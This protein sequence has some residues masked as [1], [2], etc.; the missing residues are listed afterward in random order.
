VSGESVSQPVIIP[1]TKILA[2]V[3]SSLRRLDRLE[4]AWPPAV[5]SSACIADFSFSVLSFSNFKFQALFEN[6]ISI[7]DSF[8][9]STLA[10][11][12]KRPRT[13]QRTAQQTCAKRKAPS[14]KVEIKGTPSVFNTQHNVPSVLV[15]FF[16]VVLASVLK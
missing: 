2:R 16:Q 12:S 7:L 14:K 15:Q 3:T 9:I 6:S 13:A 1:Q 4:L 10:R 8:E 5:R 11:A